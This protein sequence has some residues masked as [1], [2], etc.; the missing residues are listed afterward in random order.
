MWV[1]R[2][3]RLGCCGLVGL[4]QQDKF[5]GDNNN[6]NDN[7]VIVCIARILYV[8]GGG[9]N[10]CTYQSDELIWT[11][12]AHESSPSNILNNWNLNWDKDTVDKCQMWLGPFPKAYKD[13]FACGYYAQG[14][15]TEFFHLRILFKQK[16]MQSGMCWPKLI[17]IAL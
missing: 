7:N 12:V 11:H 1:Q 10:K 9:A 5:H 13:K 15:L 2:N 16:R 6:N 4:I 8:F 3:W 14:L 17:L